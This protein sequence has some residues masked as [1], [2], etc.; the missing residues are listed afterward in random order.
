MKNRQEDL[1]PKPKQASDNPLRIDLFKMLGSILQPLN[2][3]SRDKD[4]NS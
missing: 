2:D 3:D 4:I 1:T